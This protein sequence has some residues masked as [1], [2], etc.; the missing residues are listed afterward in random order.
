MPEYHAYQSVKWRVTKEFPFT[1]LRMVKRLKVVF[2][3]KLVYRLMRVVAL[4]NYDPSPVLSARSAGGLNHQ[5]KPSLVRTKIGM[6]KK[7]IGRYNSHHA[8]VFEIQPFRK[9][10]CTH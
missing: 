1:E 4:N 5:L 2:S 10:L 3:N 6:V 8:Y 9:H 7:R